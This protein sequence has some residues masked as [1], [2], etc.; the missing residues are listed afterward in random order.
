MKPNRT[1]VPQR[2]PEARNDKARFFVS[3]ARAE[4]QAGRLQSAENLARLAKAMA[5]LDK[6]IRE[7]IDELVRQRS[8]SGK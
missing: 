8:A 4:Q 7:L 6:G 5:P 2:V 3:Q 1:P